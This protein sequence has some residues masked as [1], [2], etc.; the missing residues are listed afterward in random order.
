[1]GESANA[2][3]GTHPWLQGELSD[4]EALL[5]VGSY[6][7]GTTSMFTYLAGHP[8]INPATIKEPGFF[9][10]QRWQDDPPAY[11]R[12]HE[13]ESYLSLF[14]GRGRVLLEG[15]SNYLHDPGC[16]A[17]I[18]AALPNARVI[19]ML[20]EPV[21]RLISWYRF[22]QLQGWLG[23][24][25]AFE[26]WVR[27]QMDDPR[28]VNE[29]PYA[30]QALQHGNYAADV[31]VFLKT[32]G[33]HAMVVWF[34]EFKRDPERV[35]R[36]VCALAGIDPA[37]YQGYRFDTRNESMQIR[38]ERT[39]R[40]YRGAHRGFFRL[41]RHFPRLQFRLRELFYSRE[42]LITPLFTE[43]AEPVRVPMAL[44]AELQAYYRPGV[45]PLRAVTGEDP[46]WALAYEH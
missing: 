40:W 24:D 3:A 22:L 44:R 19:I 7:C 14:R 42:H 39:F 15:T 2:D 29:R 16:A 30:L 32:F 28:P 26:D 6:R 1:M 4:R 31:D 5:V 35:M 9:F 13:A 34:D 20:R 37:Y 45:A 10:S 8:D 21:A 36:R 23:K 17:R 33:E 41:F 38:S 25:V 12:G 46:P 43:P 27:Q 18:H 11:P